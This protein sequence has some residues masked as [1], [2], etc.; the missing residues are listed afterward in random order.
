MNKQLDAKC[1]RRELREAF[2][3]ES[4]RVIVRSGGFELKIR[5]HKFNPRKAMRVVNRWYRAAHG[6]KVR[7]GKTSRSQANPCKE[8]S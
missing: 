7:W 5:N 8:K 4:I 6:A 2:P 3:D 1:I